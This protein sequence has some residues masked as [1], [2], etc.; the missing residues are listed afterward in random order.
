MHNNNRN[1]TSS[2]YPK[3][4]ATFEFLIR[5]SLTLRLLP[6]ANLFYKTYAKITGAEIL[7]PL[8]TRFKKSIMRKR[9]YDFVFHIA[10]L[11]AFR[12]A[13]SRLRDAIHRF[14]NFVARKLKSLLASKIFML[15]I[16][17][18]IQVFAA[19]AT[20][21]L[22]YKLGV[23]SYYKYTND[24]RSANLIKRDMKSRLNHGLKRL[25]LKASIFMDKIYRGGIIAAIAIAV[26]TLA[27]AIFKIFF[28]VPI[29]GE[30]LDAHEDFVNSVLYAPIVEEFVYRGIVLNLLNKF[31]NW[32]NPVVREEYIDKN[33][34]IE[35][36]GHISGNYLAPEDN[37]LLRG[38]VEKN[39]TTLPNLATALLFADSHSS[40]RKRGAF[41]Y[42]LVF[43][44]LTTKD[45][46]NI[47][48]SVAAHMTNNALVYGL[49]RLG[50]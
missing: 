4:K 3:T 41:F 46:G 6:L 5:V 33:Q 43:G 42:G 48:S 27:N 14:S 8:E 37:V 13:F 10:L 47:T 31:Y 35:L 29:V 24:Q 2:A 22:L 50:I 12:A 15:I 28:G 1:R 21:Y 36:I 26:A 16:S 45:N 20:V 17:R 49:T 19:A 23:Y 25:K 7:P 40:E 39:I 18:C 30:S 34:P 9:D 38:S 44:G 11:V 32:I